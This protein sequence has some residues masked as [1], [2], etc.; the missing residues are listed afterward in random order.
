MF[1]PNSVLLAL[2]DGL[3]TEEVKAA[4]RAKLSDQGD[5]KLWIVTHSH[6]NGEDLT[7]LLTKPST[8]AEDL[9]RLLSSFDPRVYEFHSRDDEYLDSVAEESEMFDRFQLVD[10]TKVKPLDDEVFIEEHDG[11]ADLL[12]EM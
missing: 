8:R 7:L 6:K 2:L 12:S 3:A 10:L 1:V 9:K 11:R 5:S 4:L